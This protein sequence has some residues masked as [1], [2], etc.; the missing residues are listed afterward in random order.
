MNLGVLLL[1]NLLYDSTINPDSTQTLEHFGSGNIYIMEEMIMKFRKRLALILA[2]SLCLSLAS[3]ASSSDTGTGSTG[4]TDAG[5][6]SSTDTTGG[7]TNS[8][9]G[10]GDTVELT[11]W[12]TSSYLTDLEL[13]LQ[14][15][16]MEANP[17]ISINNVIKEGDPGNDFYT[18]VAAG[19]APDLVTCSFT[20]MENYMNTGILEPMNAYF[21]AW[22][23]KDAFDQVYL[24]QFSKDGN[25]YGLVT[26]SAAFY[27][28]Y[29]KALFEE[30]GI[31][32]PPTTWDEAIEDATAIAALGTDITGYS[33][34]TAE[35]TDWYFQYYVWQAGGDL[36]KLNEDGTLELTFTDPAVIEAG[37]YYQELRNS[38]VLQSDLTMKFGDIQDKFAQGKIGMMPFAGDWVSGMV[39]RGMNPNDIGL[40]LFP[41]GSSGKNI[42]TDMGQTMVI[43]ATTSQEKKDAAWEYIS[44]MLSIDTLTQRAEEKVASGAA[45]P[46]I[47]ARNDFD[48][49][50]IT[51]LPAEYEAVVNASKGGRLEYEGKGIITSYVDRAVQSILVD[52]N[53]DVATE[54]QAAQDMAEAEVVDA[55]NAEITG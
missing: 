41:Q 21:D 2:G 46:I 25:L 52:P 9:G 30:A 47:Y 10:S 50:S 43:N 4:N 29:N 36:T 35:W 37:E 12:Y 31:D 38:G 24:D 5:A 17:H 20:V 19:N 18:A 15:E 11:L 53:A 34:L 7:D 3:C 40:A 26:W 55:Y 14:D 33:T 27:L 45:D 6:G 23:D 39:G 8:G 1:G 54:F 16:F 51:G 42:T 22:E 28:G 32:G 13:S 49:I 48:S 44:F